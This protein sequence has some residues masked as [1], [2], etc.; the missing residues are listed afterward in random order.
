VSDK[1]INRPPQRR[2]HRIPAD[3]DETPDE[4][5]ESL[6]ADILEKIP[7]NMSEMY[8]GSIILGTIPTVSANRCASR[9]LLA[10]LNI[11]AVLHKLTIYRI[12]EKLLNK[13]TDGLEL[14][15]VCGAAVGPVKEQDWGKSRLRMPA[16][17]WISHAE[18]PL[19]A[20][21]L[22]HALAVEIGSMDF[23]TSDIPSMSTLIG[24]Y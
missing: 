12:R 16:L 20:D 10:S 13:M 7:K 19:Q 15:D 21:G 24:S 1:C 14:G 4:M 3:E 23:N 17:M 22:C 11:T 18:R 2:Y 9:F 5:G 6:V 8:V